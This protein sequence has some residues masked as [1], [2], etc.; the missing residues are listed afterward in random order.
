MRKYIFISLA[1]WAAGCVSVETL[2]EEAFSSGGKVVQARIYSVR[3]G[4]TYDEVAAAMGEKA[5]IGY[6]LADAF[7]GTHK[8]ITV[9]N[10]YRKEFFKNGPNK[11]YDVVY[12]FTRIQKAD[13]IISDDELT[14]LIFENDVL[15]GKGWED[16]N[17]I[18]GGSR[19]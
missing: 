8:P 4:M 19:V 7:Q 2:P 15:I 17:K 3:V 13:G 12:Y 1:F 18:K 5:V 6:D 9:P 11:A 10:P 14:P 16:L